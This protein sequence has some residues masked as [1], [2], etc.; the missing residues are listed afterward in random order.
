MYSCVYCKFDNDSKQKNCW[1]HNNRLA[2]ALPRF[3]DEFENKMSAKD[4]D[5]TNAVLHATNP[6]DM[7]K[8][9]FISILEDCRAVTLGRKNA[10]DNVKSMLRVD[11]FKR[12]D[13]YLT[14]AAELYNTH[15]KC[16]L[17]FHLNCAQTNFCL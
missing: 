17:Q 10:D 14:D 8:L 3:L 7:H 15:F 2:R 12:E 9:F 1:A 5:I 6:V 11:W 4:K 13:F 16:K